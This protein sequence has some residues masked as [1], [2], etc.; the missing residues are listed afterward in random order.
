MAIEP[1]RNSSTN[2]VSRQD[3]PTD[4]TSLS[5][6][7]SRALAQV[8]V[9]D[10]HVL[11][12]MSHELGNFFHRLY[13]WAEHVRADGPT[14]GA[15]GTEREAGEMLERTIRHLE[16][17]LRVALQYF[18]PVDVSPMRLRAGDLLQSFV[19]HVSGR[20]GGTALEVE[21]PDVATMDSLVGVDPGRMMQVFEIAVRYLG[22]RLGERSRLTIA[23]ADASGDDGA[24]V[25]LR[26]MIQRPGD[27]SPAFRAAEN[28]V[29]W[30]LLLKLIQLQGGVLNEHAERPHERGLSIV[31]PVLR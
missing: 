22:Q 28:A 6:P 18:S 30:A 9:S 3:A 26:V 16:E 21:Q 23:L 20:L 10:E 19:N 12:D 8:A 2:G 4:S 7:V 11:A 13:Y 27:G 17:F 5:S 25:A 14:E 1:A 24:R 31:L 29:E 15:A